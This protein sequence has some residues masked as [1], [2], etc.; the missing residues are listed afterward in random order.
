MNHNLAR[1]LSLPDA[2]FAWTTS[3]AVIAYGVIFFDDA[4]IMGR[5][6]LAPGTLVRVTNC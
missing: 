5:T 6:I 1:D 3:A 2:L 4:V